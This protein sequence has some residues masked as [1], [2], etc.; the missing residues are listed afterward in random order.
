MPV[1]NSVKQLL[2]TQNVCYNI[3]PPQVDGTLDHLRHEQYLR[4]AGAVKSLILQDEQGKVQVLIP[5][6]C[7][8]DLNAVNQQLQRELRAM[9]NEEL[10]QFF[11]KHQFQSMPALPKLT[12]LPTLVDQ[13]LLQP[14]AL[15]LDA[16]IADQLLEL[17]QADFQQILAD[18]TI[19]DITTPLANLEAANLATQNSDCDAAEMTAA[20]RNF[21]H[22]RV[23]QRLEETLELPPLPVT[24]Q[25]IIKLRV[26]P[27]ADISDLANI[28]ETD[29]SLA[30][31][32]VSWAASPYYSAPGKIKSIHDAIVRVLGF[33][34]VLNLAL[35]L[36]LGKTLNLPK[37]GPHGVTPYWQIAVCTAATVEGLVTAIPREH[38]PAFGMAYLSGLLNNFGYLILAEVFPP[39]FKT[40]SRYTEANPHV[41][42]ETI[43]RHILGVTRQ[44]FASWLMDLWGMPQEIVYAL[45]HQN[46]PNYRG[47]HGEYAQ[48]VFVA[49]CLLRQQGIGVGPVIDVPEDVYDF[50]HLDG[51]QAQATITN[52]MESL[53]DLNNIAKQ[54]GGA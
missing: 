50:L 45:R 46:N 28:V 32:V 3:S 15:L 54:L 24:A 8:L 22:L 5:A 21:T 30:A 4:N 29:P 11:D 53:D 14:E 43:E 19:C 13:R 40:I 23:K 7:L 36:A 18:A 1:P 10:R 38:R 16:G 33:D 25:R 27:N 17:K 37:D 20:I 34:M 44:H 52:I 31:Q 6:N 48:L 41:H 49:Q 39:Y 51:V 42:T 9:P 47:E 26:E 12:G 2:E 35:G